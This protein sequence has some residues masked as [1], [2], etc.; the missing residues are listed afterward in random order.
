MK[1][2]KHLSL[3]FFIFVLLAFSIALV[4]CGG[5]DET[6]CTHESVGEDGKCTECGE[7]V[8]D[9]TPPADEG[10]IVLVK[11]GVPAFKFVTAI[12]DATVISDLDSLIDDL[13]ELLKEDA[14]RVADATETLGEVEI[15]VGSVNSRGDAFKVDE[16]YLGHNGYAVKLVD[17]KIVIYAGATDGY[18]KAFN[19][20]KKEVLGI[21][22]STKALTD[23]VIDTSDASLFTEKITE[24]PISVTIEGTPLNEYVF[25]YDPSNNALKTFMNE[26]RSAYYSSFGAWCE[27]VRLSK[28][29][30]GTKAIIVRTVENDGTS[31]GF[32]SYVT[33]D[34]NLVIECMYPD[35][36]VEGAKSILIDRIA[37]TTRDLKLREG[38]IETKDYR[39]IYYRDFGAKGNGSADDFLAI[40]ACHEYAN[41]WGH[42][43]NSDGPDA[44]YYIG[45]GGGYK[46]AIIGTPTNWH[47][48]KFIFDDE[49]IEKGSPE[50]ITAIFSVPPTK[51][52]VTYT[53]NLPFT[54]LKKGATRVDWAPGKPMLIYVYNG[55]IKHYIRYGLNADKGSDQKE[56]LLIDA[57]G[58]IDPST[59]VQ[60]EYEVVTKI[61]T[62]YTGDEELVISGGE[63]GV[64]ALIETRHN[65]APAAYSY[66]MRNIHI[67]RSNVTI[68]NIEHVITEEEKQLSNPDGTGDYLGGHGAPYN[69]FTLIE[70][71]TG[72]TV[73]NFIFQCP[74]TYY[75]EENGKVTK[76]N[77][78]SYEMNATA[79][80]NLTYK[81]CTQSNFF[82]D[83]GSVIFKGLMGTNFCKNLAFDNMFVTSFDAHCGVY[84]VTI[85]DSTCEHLN[86]IGDGLIT[87]E[88]VTIYTDG[89]QHCAFNLRGD[90]GSTWAGDILV[91]GLTLKY[92]K[93]SDYTLQLFN[94]QYYDHFFGYETYLPQNVTINNLTTVEYEFGLDERGDRWETTGAVNEYVV[95]IFSPTISTM[96][97]SSG[98]IVQEG[99]DPNCT[100]AELSDYN[101]C[102]ACGAKLRLNIN[103]PTKK[104]IIN[105]ENPEKPVKF[106]WMTG[107]HF[108]DTEIWIDGKK[109]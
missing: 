50:Q 71:C 87:Y 41:R 76:N 93:G 16:H 47:G 8:N 34:G 11:D 49:E 80:N 36:I 10:K 43:V 7:Q 24:Y 18:E 29:E 107:T 4:A 12:S 9:P 28:L 37:A 42:T 3:L 105:N 64:R 65:D 44:V 20:L 106:K 94:V 13:N 39:N 15:I 60:W 46:S 86:F 6:P 92:A 68:K 73:D 74:I 97:N 59:P 77:M 1:K 67:T 70:Y 57:E 31:D 103:H 48:C 21:S 69:G 91:N 89:R 101:R 100:H 108:E 61:Q 26:V 104:I 23:V 51:N 95:D 99:D 5:G 19:W 35:K 22:K 58:N 79:A 96:S 2:R 109:Q 30:E 81:N 83:D 63:D 78:G 27:A 88:N 25:A 32:T 90:Y 52:S 85:K 56:I 62:F 14:V 55:N 53:Q 54:S 75:V 72:V 84:N 82:E 40:V 45:K 102:T 33:E 98:I 38:V 17:G 66:Y